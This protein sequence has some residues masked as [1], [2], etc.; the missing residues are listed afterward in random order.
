MP[1]PRRV[2]ASKKPTPPEQKFS[3]RSMRPIPVYVLYVAPRL[4]RRYSKMS[5]YSSFPNSGCPHTQKADVYPCSQCQTVTALAVGAFGNPASI[6]CP[7]CGKDPTYRAYQKCLA[8]GMI[9]KYYNAV[10]V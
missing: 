1:K 2:R 9:L 7:G 4:R 6:K 10:G 3:I 8:C 5:F